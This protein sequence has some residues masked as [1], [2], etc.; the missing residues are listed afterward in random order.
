MGIVNVT[1]DSFSDGGDWHDPNRAVA[2]ALQLAAD[3][4]DILD[5]GGESTRPGA[6]PVPLAEELR[7]TVPVIE[8]VRAR[9]SL[10]ISID[11]YKAEV[12]RQ[13]LNAGA[14]IVNDVSG[15]T[16][17]PRMLEVCAA[18]DY[19][20]ICMHIQGT[21]QTMQADP[22]YNDVVTDIQTYF[23]ER[24]QSCR[25]PGSTRSGWS[26]IPV[27]ASAK[28]PSTTWKSSHMWRRSAAWGVP[29]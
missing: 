17:D 22:R 8:Q 11:T 9:C 5:I 24:L 4:A 13:A 3:G 1:P 6:E 29:Y 14:T 12:A 27:S 10:P 18:G 21:P 25:R 19:G 16:F 28:R 20:V 7:R 15:L 2:R 26:W 23:R